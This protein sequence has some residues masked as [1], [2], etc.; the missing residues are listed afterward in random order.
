[1]L[2]EILQYGHQYI[3]F[4]FVVNDENSLSLFASVA[5]SHIKESND[6]FETNTILPLEYCWSRYYC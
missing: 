2:N 4:K 5:L 3:G 6:E 1:M